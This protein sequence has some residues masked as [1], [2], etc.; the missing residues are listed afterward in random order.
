MGCVVSVCVVCVLYVCVVLGVVRRMNL[1]GWAW[2]ET[3]IGECHGVKQSITT[4]VQCVCV[5]VLR[6]PSLPGSH[7]VLCP[8]R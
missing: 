1:R 3:K 5:C 7:L 8:S 2:V 4:R 6:A